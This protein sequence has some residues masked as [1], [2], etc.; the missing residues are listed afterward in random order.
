L[1]NGGKKPPGKAREKPTLQGATYSTHTDNT[2]TKQK[3]ISCPFCP[4]EKE[5]SFVKYSHLAQHTESAHPSESLL[6]SSQVTH[7][8][9]SSP[10]KQKYKESDKVKHARELQKSK[11]CLMCTLFQKD[12]K[13]PKITSLD[14][15]LTSVN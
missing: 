6:S 1:P 3:A 4:E 14:N 10:M 9:P 11:V 13:V 5:K 12:L 7:A 8:S 15:A 2:G